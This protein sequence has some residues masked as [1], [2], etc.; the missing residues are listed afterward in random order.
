[1]TFNDT[2]ASPFVTRDMLA[3]E[4]GATFGLEIVTRA[5]VAGDLYVRGATREGP[6]LYKVTTVGTTSGVTSN[7]RIPDVPIWVSIIDDDGNYDEG[8]CFVTMRITVNGDILYALSSGYV[9]GDKPVSWPAVS[10]TSATNGRGVFRTIDSPDAAAGEEFT[11]TIPDNTVNLV[12]AIRFQFVAAAAAA[13]RRVHLTFTRAG[14]VMFD[15]FGSIDQIINET[16]NYS[17]MPIG[18]VPDETDGSDI[19]IPIPADLYL[20]V[21]D[22]IVSKTTAINAGDNFGVASAYVE[23]WIAGL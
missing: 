8:Q 19:I 11:I 2:L 17:C 4:Q 9:H 20:R 16:K 7:F 3:F 5:I 21:N 23:T 13:S 10:L 14:T 1:M 12:R 18:V 22:T 15:C 6:F